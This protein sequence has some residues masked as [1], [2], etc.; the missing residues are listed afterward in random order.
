MRI[1]HSV[2]AVFLALAAPAQAQ[3]AWVLH[4][5]QA[6][7]FITNLEAYQNSGDDPVVIL[8]DACPEVNRMKALRKMQK[9]S[10]AINTGPT[11]YVLETGEQKVADSMI[12]YNQRELSC[13]SQLDIATTDAPVLLP[14]DPCAQ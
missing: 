3:E 4:P 6:A 7:C 13:L 5:E 1:R 9:N 8:L 2:S 14:Q 10:A 11:I 12:V